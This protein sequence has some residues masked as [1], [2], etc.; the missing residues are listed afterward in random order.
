MIKITPCP[1]CHKR[2]FQ[3]LFTKAGRR[4]VRCRND[5]LVMV[6]PQLT[7]PEIHHLYN[8]R[9]FE[10]PEF[11]GNT[12]IGYWAYIDERPL[13][14]EYFRRKIALLKTYLSQGKLLEIGCGHGFFLEA[15]RNSPF[16]TLGIDISAYAV[17]YAQ[18]QRLPARLVDLEKAHFPPQSFDAVVAFQLI[19][20]IPNPLKFMREVNRI[21]KPSGVVLL[22]TPN[23]GGYLRKIMGRHWL[24]YRHAE[25]LFFFS[26]KTLGELL[27]KSGFSSTE[28]LKDETRFYP[29][30]HLLGGVKYYF[31][32]KFFRDVAEFLGMILAKLNLLDFKVPLPLDT[33]IVIARR[34]GNYLTRKTVAPLSEKISFRKG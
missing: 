22:A 33:L 26:P 13:L 24:S 18:K 3:S 20:H 23:E 16:E 15:A 19:E 5:N 29:L 4:I 31:K 32:G 30:R 14:L 6:N 11:R 10:S 7:V 8:D 25:H 21:L 9:Y 1:L 27:S 12:C 17:E 28:F 34:R 2:D